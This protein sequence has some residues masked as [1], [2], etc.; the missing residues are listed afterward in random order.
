MET[1]KRLHLKETINWKKPIIALRKNEK[2]FNRG[3]GNSMISNNQTDTDNSF[4]LCYC[5]LSVIRKILLE[6]I[7]C[8][9]IK[10]VINVLLT[11]RADCIEMPENNEKEK[12]IIPTYFELASFPNVIRTAHCTHTYKNWITW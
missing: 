5:R 9:I 2:S 7:A 11:S 12:K 1:S 6:T 3:K 4:L 8:K 10:K